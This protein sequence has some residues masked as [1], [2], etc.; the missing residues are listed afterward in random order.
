MTIVN[1]T[2]RKRITR[3]EKKYILERA[4]EENLAAAIFFLQNK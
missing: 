3:K 1:K 2:V 4:N